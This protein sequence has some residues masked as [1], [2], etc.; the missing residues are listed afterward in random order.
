M[1]KSVKSV[2]P[3]PNAPPTLSYLVLQK[4]RAYARELG[5]KTTDFTDLTDHTAGK[6]EADAH[7][8]PH[9]G[10]LSCKT[11]YHTAPRGSRVS[12]VRVLR[13]AADILEM[14][15]AEVGLR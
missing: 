11:E 4:R 6:A 5:W 10:S 14:P 12:L 8:G 13:M 2:V 7:S 9:L 1:V 3:Y 15:F